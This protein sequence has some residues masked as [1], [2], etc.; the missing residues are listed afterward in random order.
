ML[1]QE[2]QEFRVR[3]IGASEVAAILGLDPYRS[4]IDIYAKKLGLVEDA[5][6]FHTE[7][8]NFIEPG[9]RAWA[10]KRL[11]VNFQPGQSRQ[12]AEHA[13]VLATPD[14]EHEDENYRIA[15]VLELK[16][17]GFRTWHEWGDGDDAPDRYVVQVVQQ[18]LVT[19]APR[20]HLA[21]WLGD[22]L[23]IYTF[24]RDAELEGVI[25][26]SIERFWRDYIETQTPP[27]ADGSPSSREWLSRR[28]PRAL[29]EMIRA[30]DAMEGLLLEL[31]EARAAQ[32]E[33]EA[34]RE[35]VEQKLKEIIG[36]KD[37]VAGV[38]GKVTWRNSKGTTSIDWAAMAKHLAGE[39]VR[40]LEQ[41]FLKTKPGPRVF[42]YAAAKE[43]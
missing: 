23:R 3:G 39:K 15:N 4:P 22:D 37:G 41:Q 24:E 26:E 7:R 2:Q 28:F 18:M 32:A 31:R 10:S 13:H 11:G 14:G 16:S 36:D 43:Q 17:P 25:V 42:R 5:P 27:P 30:D 40:Q 6:S 19:G 9:L 8:G 20:G 38:S 33:A 34:R 29:G 12:H 35:L 1:T 21:A